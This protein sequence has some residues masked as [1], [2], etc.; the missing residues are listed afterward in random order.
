MPYKAFVCFEKKM[1]EVT[2]ASM[3]LKSLEGRILELTKT[4][5]NGNDKTGKCTFHFKIVG[6]NGQDIT[7][8]QQ[9]KT[10]FETPPICFFVHPVH[11]E[12]KDDDYHKMTNPLVLLTGAARYESKDF[13]P[14]V[15]IDLIMLRV[16]FEEIYGYEVYCT[17]DPD[18]SETESLT[19]NQLN[20]FLMKHYTNI[21][22]TNNEKKYDALIFVWCGHGNTADEGDTLITSDND[23]YKPFKKVQELFAYDTDVFLNKPKIFIKNA[24]RGNEQPKQKKRGNQQQEWYNCESD[25][26]II[27]STTPGKLIFDSEDPDNGKGSY[28]TECFCN[29]MSQNIIS[30]ISLDDNLMLISKLVKQKALSGQIIQVITTC[31]RHVFLYNKSFS[32]ALSIANAEMDQNPLWNQANKKAYEI[33][34]EMIN[35]KQQGIVVVATNIDQFARPNDK[36]FWQEIPFTMMINSIE[37]MKKKII[38]GPYS[39]YSFH[40]KKIIFDDITI[41]GCVY[42]VDS[43]IDGFGN[44]H[45]TQQLV[46]TDSS[47]ISCDFYSPVLTCSWPIHT[48]NVMELGIDSLA[49]PNVDKAI[50]LFRFALCVRLQTLPDSHIDVAESYG[51]LGRAYDDKGEYDTAIEYYQKALKIRLD[52]LGSDHP[53]VATLYNNL[54]S[55]YDD[56]GEYHKSIEYYEKDLE[57]NLTKLGPDHPNVSDSYNNLGVV[58]DKIGEYDKAMEYYEKSLKIRLEKLGHDHPDVAISYKNVGNVY[59]NKGE[60][61]KAI[62]YF[63]KSL[64]IR[65]DKLGHC[66]PNVADTYNSLGLVYKKKGEY[67]K[68]IEYYDKSLK[69]RLHKLG[70]DHPNVA[71]LYN[72]LTFVYYD[73]QEYDKAMEFGKKALELRLKKLDFDHPKIGNS[74][75]ILGDIHCKK[76]DKVEAKK[77]YEKALSIYTQ[78]LGENNQ[79]T[80]N[81]ISAL[82]KL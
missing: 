42:V 46:H 1:H 44:C 31:D 33:V 5:K 23:K 77:C 65:L 56:K 49:I 82:K 79:K 11:K 41:D 70:P 12:G 57:I 28:F 63:E 53:D 22:E 50:E 67:S 55:V 15:K 43:I 17:Y 9:L 25:T 39:V 32:Y 81:V 35:H 59:D 61:D 78:K 24:C 3:D 52:I 66:H 21:V 48:G 34:N 19:L 73:K 60:Y 40:S 54:G 74:Y 18:K 29:V 75:H 71:T 64:Q 8:D 36:W 45:I 51:W 37:Y 4:N 76:G 20:L 38:I 13:L 58:H 80:K 2:L 10:A 47:V 30:S 69:I 27:F 26:F 16:L 7:N 6:N 14:G 62:E 68:A 72:N